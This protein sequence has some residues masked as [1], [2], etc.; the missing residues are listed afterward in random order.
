MGAKPLK[1]VVEQIKPPYTCTSPT[2]IGIRHISLIILAFPYIF[3]MRIIKKP[4]EMGYINPI[5]SVQMC[6]QMQFCVYGSYAHES[7]VPDK[8]NN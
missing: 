8:Q 6:T 4:T 2:K 1:G 5:F 7:I 3:C